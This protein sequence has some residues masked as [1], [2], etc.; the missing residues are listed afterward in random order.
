[1]TDLEQALDIFKAAMLEKFHQRA[2]KHGERSVTVSG[3]KHLHEPGVQ[4]GLWKHFMLEVD[5]FNDAEYGTE[6][7]EE[8]VDVA[9]MAFLIWWENR[10][11]P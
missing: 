5:E 1:M 9:N 8:A 2:D 7:M 3:S 11:T 6:E 10:G 4:E